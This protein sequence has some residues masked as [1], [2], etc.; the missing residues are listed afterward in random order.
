M[1][2]LFSKCLKTGIHFTFFIMMALFIQNI[3]KI[4][5]LILMLLIYVVEWM[6][7]STIALNQST[8]KCCRSYQVKQVRV[9]YKHLEDVCGRR[10]Y[11]R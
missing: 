3:K 11:I 10:F 1:K 5:G 8:G 4:Y 6:G 7:R 2:T 9:Y